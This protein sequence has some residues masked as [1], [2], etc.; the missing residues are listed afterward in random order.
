MRFLR[1]FVLLLIWPLAGFAQ[2]DDRGYIQ[3]LLEDAL[4]EAGREVRIVGFEG[5]LSSRATIAEI[6]VADED[7]V[8]LT[9][10]DVAMIWTRGAL[11]RGA[12]EIDEISAARIEIPR[13]PVTVSEDAPPTPEARSP[14]SLPDL[15]VSL[16]LAD[17]SLAE[18]VLGAPIAGE[19][20]VFQVLGKAQLS[21]GEGDAELTV[22]RL[23]AG[24]SL[25]LS[26]AYSNA[27]RVLKLDTRFE[28]PA[29]GLVSRK[30]GL[31]G[32]PSVVLSVT[33]DAPI[34][35][36]A[37]NLRLATDGQERLAGE[38]VLRADGDADTQRLSLD[39]GGDLAPLLAPDYR[40]FLG[41]DIS[42]KAEAL[43]RGDG[44]LELQDLD[45][46]AEALRLQGSA[47]IGSDGWPQRL[48]LSGQIVPP[49]GEEVLLPLPGQKVY[50]G[51]SVLSAT[52]DASRSN[53]WQLALDGERLTSELGAAGAL[54]LNA[55]GEIV[56]ETSQVTG[57]VRLVAA[58]LAP[59]DP[60]LAEALGE[61]LRGSLNFDWQ[62]GEPL[63]VSDLD[64][65]GA[66]YGLTGTISVDEA[67]TLN[68]VIA[69][70]LRLAAED[71]SRFASLAGVA[72]RGAAELN[73]SGQATPVTGA[74]DLSFDGTTRDLGTGIDRVDPLIAG[75]ATLDLRAVRDEAGL[76]AERLLLV[77]PQARIEGSGSFATGASTAALTARITETSVVLPDLSGPTV[78]TLAAEQAGDVWSLEAQGTLAE[79]GRLDYLGTVDLGG[80][81][82]FLAGR[83]DAALTR[84]DGFSDLAGRQLSGAG[85]ITLTGEGRVDGASFRI[86]AEGGLQDVGLSLP[87]IDPLLRGRTQLS[88]AAARTAN[89]PITFDPLQLTGAV[90][91][92]Y[93][94]TVTPK[95]LRG[96]DVNGTLTASTASLSPLSAL[97]GRTLRGAAQVEA[98]INGGVTEGPLTLIGFVS[99]QGLG[100]GMDDV[101]SL[102]AGETR[103]DVSFERDAQG[104]Y[105]FDQ[106]Q[107]DGAVDAQFV[108][109]VTPQSD[110]GPQV[111]GRLTASTA[112]LAPLSGLAGRPLRGSAQIEATANGGILEGALTLVG[113]VQ[114]RGLALDLPDIDPLLS[115]DTRLD[116]DLARTDAGLY[117]IEQLVLDGVVDA[118]FTGMVDPEVEGGPRVE[119]QL[120]ASVASLAPLSRLANM[121]LSGAAQIEATAS[122]AL[123]SGALDLDAVVRGQGLGIGQA[124]VDPLLRG[125]SRLDV[126]LVRAGSGALQI[127]SLML[128]ASGVNGNVTGSYG[129]GSAADLR[130]EVSLPN[131][132]VIV[133]ELPGAARVS[134]TAVQAD[135]TW[136]LALDGTGPGGIGARVGGTAAGDFSQVNLSLNG[137]APLSLAN[138]SIAP[139]VVTGVAQFDLLMNGAPSLAALSGSVS[140]NGARFAAPA[141]AIV[142]NDLSGQA[143][144]TGGRAELN[145]GGSLNSGGQVVLTG[146]V[147]L[148]P[149]F[150]AG[151]LLEL[152][153]AVLQQAGLFETTANGQVRVDG[154][155]I[156]GAVIG[157]VVDLGTVEARIPDIGSSYTSLDGLKH[158][159]APRDV[160]LTLQFAG[161]DKAQ[162]GAGAGGTTARPYPL[163]LTVQADNRIFVR[164][165][166]LDAELGGT[167]R[168]SGTT[169]NV[170]PVGQFDLIRG[171]LDLLGRRLDLTEGSVFLRGSFD[172]V[173]RFVATTRVED[174]D[175]TITIEGPASSPELSVGS[176]PQLP[177]DEALSFFLFGRSVTELS[178]LQ[179]V[180]LASAIRTLSGRGGLGLTES[181]RGGLGVSDLDVGT[182]DDGTAQ[183][184]VGAYLGENIYSDVTVN[185]KGDSEINLNLTVTPD[186][187]V[188]GRLGSDG[189]SGIGVFFERDY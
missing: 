105:R 58:E 75:A 186:V 80:E 65:S 172:P 83:L 170:V 3:G 184:R 7:G 141:Q 153:Q 188:R 152:R 29:G 61:S 53:A 144:L 46:Q 143:R 21:G 19:E 14:F 28:E 180:Q 43:R 76:R 84:L 38:V 15:P 92:R 130:L 128:D 111:D 94:G 185:A 119:G 74:F 138:G 37:A 5:A 24:G 159:N 48:D 175:I 57:A 23:D 135:G 177:E 59:A 87:E 36:F 103:L 183:A 165:R 155:L 162:Q 100:I 174:T 6:T 13:L 90:N 70:D 34:D 176:S 39:I 8:W 112:S 82:P 77:S 32:E 42:L 64:L 67:E 171:R 107:L 158:V 11:L 12:V 17:L 71:L 2:E 115:G 124:M 142:L 91:A 35:D 163:D 51:G 33:G 140:T 182:A 27:S 173:I 101:D 4:S 96:A 127:S 166:G 133:P 54:R 110:F 156:G 22:Q 148:S 60:A 114:G 131:L 109:T 167:L 181:L 147:T 16:R 88:V 40:E 104:T 72:L 151:L 129:P 9:M 145:F 86:T 118:R 30:L 146:P 66:D 136:R 31:P 189:S 108:G 179:A 117:R 25:R 26:G 18:V 44:A 85:Q 123:Q 102:L 79:A 187:T 122:G 150:N 99:G 121:P 52:F 116:V 47:E 62:Q 149:P 161:L 93:E 41:R 68:P 10:T 169:A 49:E 157:G 1:V 78:L 106:L 89:G 168:L 126:N 45:L 164:G 113:F 139:Q 98:Q 63:T 154:P 120:T 73:I 97:A 20:L 134:G 160:Q 50:L 69:P 55:S 125:A 56:R 132:G 178:A 81:V 137:S 95:G